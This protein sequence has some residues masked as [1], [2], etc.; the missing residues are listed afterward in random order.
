VLACDLEMLL[1]HLLLQLLLLLLLLRL[2]LLP[3]NFCCTP[4]PYVF[5]W[6][7]MRG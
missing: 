3:C 7:H 6:R 1:L 5:A 4:E 2:L